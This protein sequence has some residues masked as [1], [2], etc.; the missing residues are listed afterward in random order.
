MLYRCRMTP[1]LHVNSAIL[2]CERLSAFAERITGMRKSV[3]SAPV[4]AGPASDVFDFQ[5]R[6]RETGNVPERIRRVLFVAHILLFVLLLSVPASNQAT[7]S[8]RCENLTTAKFPN[9]TIT[10]A[11][12]VTGGE[13]TP[14]TPAGGNAPPFSA[15]QDLPAFCRVAATLKPTTDSDIKLE[16]WMPLSGWNGK[17]LGVGNFGWAGSISYGELPDP[18]RRGYAVASTDTGHEGDALDGRFALGHPE[19]LVDFGY[20]AVHEMT[21]T[22]KALVRAFYAARPRWSYWM[23]S[24]TGGKQG[25]TE[26]Q[27]FPDDYD[28]IVVGAP[29]NY[30]T[31]VMSHL[32]WIARATLDDPAHFVA[33]HKYP[34]IHDAVLAACDERDGLR[35]SLVSDPAHCNFDPSVL[36]CSSGDAPTCLTAPQ[37]EAV[38]KIYGPA[39]N[40]RTGRV[41]SPGLLPGSEIGWEAAAGGPGPFRIP[42]DFFKYV[43]FKNPGWDFHTLDFDRD[44]ALAEQMDH[45]VLNAI[46][47]DLRRFERTG[48]KLLMFHGWSDEAISPLNTVEY[49][50]S[51]LKTMG[52]SKIDAFLRLF[53]VPGMGHSPRSDSDAI[54]FDMTAALEQWVE[55]GVAPTRIIAS[56]ISHGKVNR[57]LL[58][59]PYPQ[60][61]VYKGADGM[62]AANFTCEVR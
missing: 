55:H 57:T 34:V 26:A 45:G 43:V 18:L 62:D 40:P 1:A 7:P 54:A 28:G 16:L 61:A 35:D 2:V 3:L 24:S 5:Y 36:L 56:H 60:M 15:I 31:R 42:D 50:Q 25:L 30:L 21:V 49:Y 59:C 11:K 41:I 10:L 38:K 27:R 14:P 8:Q 23:G 9:T 22:A 6:P 46:D 37:V 44:V 51:V 12:P 33:P 52:A 47:P 4:R 20:R 39:T 48:G 58:L 13:F 53:M 17:F 19:K 29:V 32:I